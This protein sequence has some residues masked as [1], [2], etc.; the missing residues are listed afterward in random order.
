[1][2][3]TVQLPR[4]SRCVVIGTG[5]LGSAAA[6]SLSRRLG[7]GV[8][9]LEQFEPGHR[10]GSSED[11]SRIIRHSY[12]SEVYTAL[13]PAMFAAWAAVERESGER[14]IV[15]T[16]GLDLGDPAVTGSTDAIEA[17]AAAMAAHDIEFE[18]VDAEE[19]RRRWPQWHV[20]DEVAGLF[21]A[22]AGILDIGR[23][24][25]A[26]LALALEQGAQLQTAVRVQHLEERGE[27]VIVHTTHGP[28]VAE[29]VVACT[30]KWTARLL[31]GLHELPL[32][33]TA[34]QVSYVT[35]P[36]PAA[37]APERFPIWLRLGDP[38][39][40]G[41]PVYG[42]AAV[43]VAQDLGGPLVEPDDDESPVDPARVEVVMAF[44]RE[45][46]PGAVGPVALSRSCLYDLTPDRDL[47]VGPL[48]GHPRI[49]V[50]V[51]CGHAGKFGALFGEILCDLVVD[52]ATDHPIG[53]L[54]AGRPALRSG[55]LP[56]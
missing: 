22:D 41:F 33:H 10:R 9:V 1:M 25:R 36:D 28:V 12:D 46:L 26:Q 54:S 6:H 32:R 4:E 38:C 14:L 47:V 18:R 20:G 29:H 5:V 7:A 50:T 35:P 31:D 30:G 23:A 34:E 39:F 42:M 13:T 21:Q 52:G 8:L 19:I 11:H 45:H 40:Y 51:G 27:R 3:A 17:S 37:F 56:A 24:C 43:K 2:T 53:P 55:S 48:P 16:G 49:L 44:L 15:R